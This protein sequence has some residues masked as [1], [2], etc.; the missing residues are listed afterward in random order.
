MEIPFILRFTFDDPDGAKRR[1]FAKDVTMQA[2]H[3]PRIGERIVIPGTGRTNLGA[4][5]IA[6]VI[7]TPTGKVILDF[8]VE[9]LL[10]SAEQQAQVLSSAGFHEVKDAALLDE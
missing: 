2:P 8:E 3:V 5:E 7:Y 4:Y 9:G 10:V 6:D 1:R